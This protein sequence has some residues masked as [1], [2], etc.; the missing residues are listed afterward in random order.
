MGLEIAEQMNWELPDV[1]LYPT[2]GGVGLIGIYKAMCEL[3]E[4]GWVSGKLPRM[5]AVQSE[6]CSPIVKAYHEK[7]SASEFFANS[8]TI[9]F[10]INVPKAL[11]DFLVLDAIS[12]TNGCAITVSDEE[13]LRDQ[14]E[15][16]AQEGLFVCPEGA[17]NLSAV[18][19]LLANGW[20]KSQEK[21]VMLNTGSG[22]KYPDTVKISVPTLQPD[23]D[24]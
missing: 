13:I 23:D 14:S 1:L 7:K 17:A 5:V 8:S 18:K 16:A 2:G 21:V 15:L 12:K 22:L 3:K 4:I 24:L 19:K 20:I 11:G 10:G 9:A 6:G